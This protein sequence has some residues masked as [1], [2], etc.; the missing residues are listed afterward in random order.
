MKRSHCGGGCR[1]LGEVQRF[2][3]KV[4]ETCRY[5]IVRR[6]SSADSVLKDHFNFMS[7]EK[8]VHNLCSNKS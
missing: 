4:T 6:G 2:Y 8:E 5:L 3:V 1:E 7:H